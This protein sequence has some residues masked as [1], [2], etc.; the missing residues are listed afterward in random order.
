M[1]LVEAIKDVAVFA[2]LIVLFKKRVQIGHVFMICA[3]L[4]GLLHKMSF[5]KLLGLTVTVLTLP[6]SLTL[7]AALY[8]ISL[9]EKVM[10]ASGGQGR[11][12]SGLMNMSGDPRISMASLPAIIGLLPSPGGARFSAP[13]VAEASRNIDIP[14]EQNAAINYYYRHIW[15][16]YLP[17]YPASLLAVEILRVPLERFVLVMFPFSII[18]VLAGLFLFRK[19]PSPQQTNGDH[20]RHEAWK[21]VVEGVT[22]IVSIMM[23]VLVFK[24]HILL[25]LFVVITLLF[26]YYRISLKHFTKMIID[27]LEFRLLYMIFGAI[28]LRDVLVQSGSI[29]QVL[30]FFQSIGMSP[31][32]I[33]IIFP[34]MTGFLTGVTVAGVSI[35]MPVI[36]TLASPDNL[37][38]LGSLAFASNIV[39]QLLS[40]MHLCLLLSV[41][42]FC[43]DFIKTYTRLVLPGTLLLL[44]AIFTIRY[45]RCKPFFGRF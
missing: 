44:Y 5:V 10:R 25:A 24:F 6:S 38:S 22:P 23:L 30:G 8:L 29:E 26:F 36:V 33:A 39:G 4:F 2:L 15:E 35:A 9:L 43:A 40:P 21:Q 13:L 7:F 41:E 16:Y 1:V 14:G 28:Y 34:F 19:F 20:P 3:V 42:Y 27:A 11:L 17:L 37:L 32:L 18:M 12:V 45:Y 31:V